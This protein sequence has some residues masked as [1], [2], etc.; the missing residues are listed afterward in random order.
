M[1]LPFKVT[2]DDG[3]EELVTA[4]PRDVVEFERRYG[5]P[6]ST[7]SG[8]GREEYW[9]WLAWSPLNRAGRDTRDFEG[10]INAIVG[11]ELV[12]EDEPDTAPFEK[13]PTDESS[14]G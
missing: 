8:G 12:P 9:F 14:P 4:L 7:L 6:Y 10:F 5:V 11:V 2:Y 3:R 13:A 1:K